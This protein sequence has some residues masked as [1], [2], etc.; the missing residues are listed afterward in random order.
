MATGGHHSFK[1]A[2]TDPRPR[3]G[4]QRT[5]S[6]S[7]KEDNISNH[8]S[9]PVEHRPN[10][11]V[12][13]PLTTVNPWTFIHVIAILVLILFTIFIN[14]FCMIILKSYCFFTIQRQSIKISS[15]FISNR[16]NYITKIQK[17][18]CHYCNSFEVFFISY[19]IVWSGF[20]LIFA[21]SPFIEIICLITYFIQFIML[22][23]ISILLKFLSTL[24][25]IFK[26]FI[27]CTV[28]ENQQ[29][30][31]SFLDENKRK[32]IISL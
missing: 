23:N 1:T 12:H 15:Y 10:N 8:S 28:K 6:A 24:L 13:I 21:V 9:N 27:Y 11:W 19:L 14:S 26:K 32:W 16:K 31:E 5:A 29:R 18:K 4:W 25:L 22:V 7:D 20:C 2:S 3:R 30:K 17:I